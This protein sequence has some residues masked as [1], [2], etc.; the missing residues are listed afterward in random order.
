MDNGQSNAGGN[1]A[2]DPIQGEVEVLLVARSCATEAR[3][4]LRPDGPLGSYTDVTSHYE[5]HRK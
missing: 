4:K 3:A 5:Q 1:P 2:M